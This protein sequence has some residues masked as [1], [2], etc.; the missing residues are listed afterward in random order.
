MCEGKSWKLFSF[1]LQSTTETHS[2]RTILGINEPSK[3]SPLAEKLEAI[4][5]SRCQSK[6]KLKISATRVRPDKFFMMRMTF[7]SSARPLKT[8]FELNAE[9][10]KSCS[11]SFVPNSL[12]RFANDSNLLHVHRTVVHRPNAMKFIF[13]HEAEANPEIYYFK[14][15]NAFLKWTGAPVAVRCSCYCNLNR[16]SLHILSFLRS[17]HDSRREFCNSSRPLWSSWRRHN[18]ML[19]VGCTP[20][21]QHKRTNRNSRFHA[22]TAQQTQQMNFSHLFR[23]RNRK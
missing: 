3:K 20:T 22:D 10:A 5:F 17:T 7:L 2:W 4:F 16:W 12:L 6:S 18:M 8:W 15:E 14:S 13:W 19:E 23:F 11:F 21:Q 9:C 1:S